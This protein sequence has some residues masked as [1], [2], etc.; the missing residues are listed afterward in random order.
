MDT[1]ERAMRQQAEQEQHQVSDVVVS[2]AS[3]LQPATVPADAAIVAETNQAGSPAES[4]LPADQVITTP[5]A[6]APKPELYAE[7]DFERLKQL[8]MLVPDSESS[9]TMLSADLRTIKR[10]LLRNAFGGGA[11]EIEHGNIIMVTS[12]LPNEGKT[13]V[14]VNL[15]ISLAMEMDT[16]V[17][18][19]D[20]DVLRPSVSRVLDVPVKPGLVDYL[21][22]ERVELSDVLLKTNIP[23]LTILP[24]GRGHA[25]STELLHS[26]N[27]RRL[28]QELAQRYPDRVVLFDSPPLLAT[29]EAAVVANMMGQVIVVVEAETTSRAA[30]KSALDQLD[31][32]LHV[33]FILNKSRRPVHSSYYDAGYYAAAR[34]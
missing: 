33:S 19:V 22:D 26:D 31:S 21:L 6:T 9:N 23:R 4:L 24:A 20:C 2:P 8:G 32:S 12:A 3:T 34:R 27:M 15:A 18:L 29:T 1:I 30:V 14:S 5:V 28:T 13:Y 10:P 16:T 7:I 25:H 11:T 17:L